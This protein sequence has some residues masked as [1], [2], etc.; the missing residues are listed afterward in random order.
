MTSEVVRALADHGIQSGPVEVFAVVAL[1]NGSPFAVEVIARGGP[2]G[3]FVWT[4]D[5]FRTAFLKRAD[6]VIV[7]HT[8][9]G[10]STPSRADRKLTKML[11]SEG[12][13]RNIEV[14]DHIVIGRNEFTSIRET[15]W[16][17]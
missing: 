11:R 13:R 2:T 1:R 7:A 9:P 10:D 15:S 4:A 5:V 6:A 17:W 14:L 8:H 12:R 3:V 16:F